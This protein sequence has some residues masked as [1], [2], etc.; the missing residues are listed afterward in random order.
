MED[1]LKLEMEYLTE[2]ERELLE[3]LRKSFS[4]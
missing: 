1:K 2:D 3:Q 4:N